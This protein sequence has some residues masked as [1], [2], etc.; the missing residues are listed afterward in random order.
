VTVAARLTEKA[1]TL[2][3]IR[4]GLEDMRAGRTRPAEVVF[5]EMRRMLGD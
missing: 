5:E 2:E 3:G 4:E 1:V